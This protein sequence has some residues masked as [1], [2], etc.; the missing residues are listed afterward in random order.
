MI[1]SFRDKDTE[2]IFNRQRVKRYSQSVQLIAQRKLNM[3][4]AA[5]S[6]NDLKSPPGNRLKKLSGK[7][8]DQISIRVNDQWRICFSWQSGHASEVELTDYH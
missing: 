4:D 7:R 1:K 5:D 6:L 8:K 3:I 2:K